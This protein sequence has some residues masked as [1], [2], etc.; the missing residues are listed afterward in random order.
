M[1][2]VSIAKI[3]YHVTKDKSLNFGQY[4]YYSSEYKFAVCHIFS[5]P[6]LAITEKR[7]VKDYS[8]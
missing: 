2:N 6:Q 8:G 3:L 1:E 7:R 4:F 5:L